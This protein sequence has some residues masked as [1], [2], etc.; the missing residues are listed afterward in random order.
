MKHEEVE[1][2]PVHEIEVIFK[3]P[4]EHAGV[5]YQAGDKAII[6]IEYKTILEKIGV[7]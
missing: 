5:K 3:K 6:A 7:I 1:A 2:K 4:H